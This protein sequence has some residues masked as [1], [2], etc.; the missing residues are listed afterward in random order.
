M[1]RVLTNILIAGE[2]KNSLRALDVPGQAFWW[3]WSSTVGF[4]AQRGRW[5]PIGHWYSHC[6]QEQI[7][8]IVGVRTVCQV[9]E[10]S[11]QDAHEETAEALA[12]RA[13]SR[14]EVRL[15]ERK[16]RR[17][18]AIPTCLISL[19]MPTVQPNYQRQLPRSHGRCEVC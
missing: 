3:D 2:W 18:M 6:I 14:N 17:K 10:K 1:R 15:P 4:P 5:A 11:A 7:C 8:S 13:R 19:V 16:A 9:S 12:S